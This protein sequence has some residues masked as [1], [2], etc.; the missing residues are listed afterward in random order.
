MGRL[1][2]CAHGARVSVEIGKSCI[3]FAARDTIPRVPSA[4][5]KHVGNL[6]QQIYATIRRVPK[7]TVA[8]Y[9]QIAELVGLP[10][11]GR[12][13]G[14][15][16]RA[17]TPE[18]GLPWHRIVG[19]RS[20]NTAK[21]SIHDPVGG[22]MQRSMLEQEGVNFSATGSISLHLYGWLPID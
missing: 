10:R 15:A 5:A 11:G 9:G 13:V 21:V 22:G 6:Y 16:L 18:M 12:V 14:M 1:K 4:D 17:S 8:T 3:F 2:E 19:K 20:S 7:G